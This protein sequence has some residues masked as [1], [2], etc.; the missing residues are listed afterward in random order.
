ML[1]FFL[2][3][4]SAT[5]TSR[6]HW[7][8][9]AFMALSLHSAAHTSMSPSAAAAT[10]ITSTASQQNPAHSA[11]VVLVTID[12]V[13]WQEVFTGADP[14]LYG[15]NTT[16]SAEQL[17]PFLHHV[18]A[19]QGVLIGDRRRDS[20]MRVSN[21]YAVSY[22]GYQ[23]LLTGYADLRIA[24]NSK[25]PNPNVSV[26]EWLNQQPELQGQVAAF[27]SWELLPYILNTSRSQLPVNAGFMPL[28][29]QLMGPLSDKMQWLNQLQRQTPS[30]WQ[31]VRLDIFTSQFALEYLKAKQPRL[32]YVALGEP[33]DFAHGGDYPRY[34]QALQR[35][36]E[37]L[38][39]LWQ[40]LQADP[41]YRGQT[42]LIVTTDHGRG[43]SPATWSRHGS[44]RTLPGFAKRLAPPDSQGSE[45]I[46]FAA[47][48]PQIPARG[49]IQ[50]DTE[51]LQSQVA[52]T[53][54]DIFGYSYQ[55]FQYRAASRLPLSLPQ[56]PRDVAV[57][58]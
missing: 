20:R 52:S 45:Q 41:Y 2:R 22:P 18:I 30:P 3:S 51:F 15:A 43:D 31:A 8:L 9:L 10:T 50:S 28:T 24:D 7:L 35:A 40:T 16:H 54:A 12:G 46:W 14:A 42:T 13:R 37:Y 38:A 34:V 39:E 53:I 44:S 23:E 49:L 21:P 6:P 17:M 27:G 1:Q 11:K 4:N 47:V 33:D 58:P 29:E 19:K 25:K 56:R 55:Q 26:L 5:A 57:A 48:G 32:L 36:D